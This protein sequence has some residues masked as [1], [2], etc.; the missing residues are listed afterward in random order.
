MFL[1][2]FKEEL[3]NQYIYHFSCRATVYP[4]GL[5]AT[6]MTAKGPEQVPDMLDMLMLGRVSSQSKYTE[7]SHTDHRL[8]L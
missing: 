6:W 4:H 5:F 1:S 2:F 3:K 7:V 8:F